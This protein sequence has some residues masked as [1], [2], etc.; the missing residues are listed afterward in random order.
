MAGKIFINYRRVESSL[1]AQL[2]KAELDKAFGAKR[3]FLDVRGIDGGEN[4]L[5]TLER[6]VAASA[7]MVVLIGKDWVN[8][9]NERGNRRLDDPH[10][11]VRFEISQAL[12]RNLPI[13]PVSLDL[14][15]VPKATQLPDN[16]VQLTLMQAMPL[17]E[18]SFATDAEAIA[19]RLRAL[20]VK[21]EQHRFPAWARGLGLLAAFFAGALTPI[22][23]TEFGLPFPLIVSQKELQSRLAIA[24]KEA[25]GLKG[26]LAKAGMQNTELQSRLQSANTEN[27]DL[28]SR[29]A[30]ANKEA[31]GLKGDLAKA[32]MQNTEL[33]SRLQSANT[34]NADLQ[35][36]LAIATQASLDRERALKPKDI[37][38]ECA[39]CP[40][41]VVVPAGSFTMG[42]PSDEKGRFSFENPQHRV[43]FARPF[44][45]GKFAVTFH[46]W[47][48]C[49]ADSGC[50][51]YKPSDEDWGRG[52]R[53]VI[54]VNWYD[55]KSYV[56]W[57]SKK[58]GKPYR[59]LTEAEYEYVTRA[60][61]QTAYPWDNDIGR[62]KANCDGCGS[63]WDNKKQTAPVGSFA[64][65]QFGLYD[66]V[67]NVWQWGEDCWTDNYSGAP[68]NGSAWTTGDCKRPVVR[69]G[70]WNDPPQYVR[71]ANRGNT[72]T[73]GRRSNDLGFRVGRT[74]TP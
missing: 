27:A 28:Q 8:L 39:N 72:N 70:A 25:D 7:A 21:Q 35:S 55:A 58:T 57:L 37:F 19:K 14:A 71:S 26:D 43:T 38:S 1:K 2:L 22:V 73:P 24:N 64:S 34:E 5:Q 40:E 51:G 11:K 56:A 54:Y 12:L 63:E 69:G 30:I 33:Q 48:A 17:R 44:A 49:V 61:T 66:M 67:G 59:L 13:I 32:G 6:Q 18:E 42:S 50:N 45:V 41:M 62:N 52:R 53:P 23:F 68:T 74:L 47:D 31:D 65:N 46:E 36:R 4:W 16:L 3:V 9:K 20:L 10:D 29:L 60:G 15:P